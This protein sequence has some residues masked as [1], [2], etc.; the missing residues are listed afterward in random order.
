VRGRALILADMAIQRFGT[1]RKLPSGRWHA[2]YSLVDGRRLTAPSTFVTRGDA[3]AYL[4]A[5]QTD[6]SR[7]VWQDPERVSSSFADYAQ[8]W[9]VARRVKGK[10]LS[11]VTMQ[12]YRR[13][14]ERE[15]LS[16]FG[17]LPLEDITSALV[18]QWHAQ[19]TEVGST[20]AAQPY[21]LLHAI[22]ATAVSDGDLLCSPAQIRGAGLPDTRERP[23]VDRA[24]VEGL[25]AEMPLHLR[26]FVGLAF[27]G[28]LRLGE[29]LGLQVGDVV[30]DVEAG[31]GTV[32]VERQQ[33]EVD[34]TVFLVEP[35]SA[36]RRTV[37]L[38]APAV[39]LLAEHLT[40]REGAAVTDRVFV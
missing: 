10:P 35:K 1:V 11:L 21:R 13:R 4:A 7:G 18:R 37:N 14:L 19:T 17:H 29:L 34:G 31:S 3:V 16:T 15:I 24:G 32:W 40:L 22:L 23:L 5:V 20:T 25:T 26:A 27:W 33:Q 38:P 2:R 12:L 30:L 9:L 28:G 39:A 6:L 36:S 8:V